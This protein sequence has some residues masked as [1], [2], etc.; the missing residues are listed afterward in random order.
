MPTTARQGLEN[1]V[2]VAADGSAGTHLI[3]A[4]WSVSNCVR[5]GASLCYPCRRRLGTERPGASGGIQRTTPYGV[6]LGE[7][8]N[9]QLSGWM[10]TVNGEH[11]N[12]GLNAWTVYDKDE[13]IW[14]YT[15]DYTKERGGTGS[16]TG[17]GNSNGQIKPNATV[18]N[19][20]ANA[21]VSSN[22]FSAALNAAVQN[23]LGEILVAP[24][25]ADRAD[26]LRVDLPVDVL[27]EAARS[28]VGVTV[29]SGAGI[30]NIPGG[31]LSGI[32]RTARSYDLT[33]DTAAQSSYQGERLLNGRAELT[34]EQLKNCSVTEVTFSSGRTNI[35]SW[36]GGSITLSLPVDSRN[37]E[38][39]ERDTVYQI[40]ADG[41]MEEHTGRCFKQGGALYVEIDTTHL[42]TFIVV[43]N[44]EEETKE[45]STSITEADVPLVGLPS[46][47]ANYV[48]LPFAD[49]AGH[50]ALQSIGYVYQTGLMSGISAGAFQPDA[51]M[52]RAMFVTVL[53]RLSGKLAPTGVMV[54]TD[55]AANSWYTDAVA[56]A[57]SAGIV[58]G[59]SASTFSPNASI[60]REEMATMM[61]RYAKYKGYDVTAA[62]ELS[63]YA[64]A[65][66][67]HDW[68]YRAMEWANGT[69][70]IGGRT[71]FSLEPQGTAT[72]AE[73]A[74]ILVRFIEKFIPDY[75]TIR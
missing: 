8:T 75:G 3:I 31:T 41:S 73:T 16:N 53:H 42:S 49:A 30:V 39:R 24:V 47:G 10:Y 71:A 33:I 34:D 72:R 18:S 43:P 70:M 21:A 22:E 55:V 35:T 51:N 2:Y 27:Y 25:G 59:T 68:A 74:T 13:I 9:G 61:M 66:N 62:A 57:T 69:G 67:I 45:P 5:R 63:S 58:N 50:W 32:A 38:A 65:V 54:Y 60:T 52:S 19:G 23:R 37:F 6:R 44:A 29:E 1:A 14:H 7:F 64:D 48:I 28:G 15:D 17:T 26:S 11:P 4:Q 46:A 12:Q 40:S 56:W 20:G 36:N